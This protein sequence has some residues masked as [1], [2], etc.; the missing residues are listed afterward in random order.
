MQPATCESAV[1]GVF[2]VAVAVAAA[3]PLHDMTHSAI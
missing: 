1:V 3:A 2:A